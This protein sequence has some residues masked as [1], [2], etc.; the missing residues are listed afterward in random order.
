MT[1]ASPKLRVKTDN[2]S[3]EDK[4]VLRRL[5]IAEGQLEPVRVL[6]LFAGEGHIWNEMRRQSR[7]EDA[8]PPI[9][10]E[11]YTPVDSAVKQTGQLRFKITPRLIASLN[12]DSKVTEYTGNDL[13]RYNVVDVDT[14]G[15]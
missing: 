5:V 12:G 9:T 15:D 10:I 2:N 4:C 3:L 7:L 11:R 13:G 8:P 14:Y 6:D 1:V